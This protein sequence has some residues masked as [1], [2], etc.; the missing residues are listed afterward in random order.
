MDLMYYARAVRTHW[1]IFL[2]GVLVCTGAAAALAWT[3][4]EIYEAQSQFFVSP[5]GKPTDLSDTYQGGLFTEQRVQSYARIMSS[6]LLAQSVIRQLGLSE[7]VQDVQ[8]TIDASV[9]IDSVVINVTVQDE[10]PAQA[11]AIS[12]AVADQFPR[13][14]DMLERPAGG[15]ESPVKVSV[16]S[17]ARLPTDPVSPNKPL[18]LAFGL[19]FGLVVGTAGAVLREELNSRIRSDADAAATAGAPV[20]GRIPKQRN[21]GTRPLIQFDDSRSAGAEAFRQLRT[22][23]RALGA[24]QAHRS[25]LVS[26]AVESEGKTFVVA[27]LGAAFAQAGH[28]VVLVDADLR[29]PKLAELFGLESTIGLTSVLLDGI[30][31][32]D[33]LRR[34]SG[35]PLEILPSGPQA[36]NPS[37]LLESGRFSRTLSL[38]TDRADVVIVDSPALLPVTDAAILA[39]ITSGVILV[40]A[41]ASTRTDQLVAAS[42]AI[43]AVDKQVLGVVLN[44]VPAR[45]QLTYRDSRPASGAA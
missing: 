1:I 43:R 8:D 29:R 15:G 38:L 14:V 25:F 22:N 24:D 37:E 10:S 30:P 19:L 28:R 33:A 26:S 44:R 13:F 7:G 2:L 40:T 6:P 21:A 27:N 5:S 12:D 3:R 32:E 20:L 42:R 34:N 17:P 18:Y 35:L 45:E 4:T 41:S 9:P 23:L 39:R 36:G 11:K 16:T 31:L